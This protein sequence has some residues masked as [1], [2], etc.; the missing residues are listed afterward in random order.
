MR[1]TRDDDALIR[2]DAIPDSERETMHGRAAMFARSRD[3]LI[4]ERIVADAG[5]SGADLLD[6]PVAEALLTRLVVVLRARCP[7]P[8]EA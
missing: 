8:P 1:Q 3:D 2:L 4:L 6:E 7:P 5:E